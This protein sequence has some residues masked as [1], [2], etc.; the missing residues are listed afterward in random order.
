VKALLA[1]LLLLRLGRPIGDLKSSRAWANI[2]P[3]TKKQTT[4][5]VKT[6]IKGGRLASNHVRKALKVKAGVKG[7]RLASNHARSLRAI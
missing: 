5:K 2:R 6:A 1:A 3:M 4:L 7:G